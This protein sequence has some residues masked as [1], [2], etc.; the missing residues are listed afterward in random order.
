MTQQISQ[1]SMQ[2]L[3]SISS[4]IK[5]ILKN[6]NNS[7]KVILSNGDVQEL[8]NS[9][10]GYS[11]IV[12]KNGVNRTISTMMSNYDEIFSI[13]LMD[14]TGHRYYA[15][16]DVKNV[17]KFNHDFYDKPWERARRL[18][19]ESY[20]VQNGGDIFKNIGAKEFVSNIRIVNDI[21]TQKPIGALLINISKVELKQ[22]FEDV[23][24]REGTQI[25]LLDDRSDLITSSA[26]YND[27]IKNFS[28]DVNKDQFG[29][30]IDK[31]SNIIYSYYNI[32]E[33]NWKIIAVMPIGGDKTFFT[34]MFASFFIFIILA[35]LVLLGSIV[36]AKMITKPINI[37][38]DSMVN[39]G[40]GDLKKVTFDT[41]I[42][43]F[44]SLRDGYNSM[45]EEIQSLLN[46][47]ITQEKKKRRAELETLQAQIK[48]HFLYNTFD[49]IS[50]LALMGE[51]KKVYEMVSSLGNFY[52]ISLSKGREIITL[53]QELDALKSY[54]DILKVRYD[55]FTVNFDIC[56]EYK[57]FQ[58]L[59]LILQPF[60]ENSIY[61]GIKPKGEPG[62][63][64]ISTYIDDNFLNIK[65]MD[66]GIGMEEKE[67]KSLFS[68]VNSFGIKGTIQR[69]LLYYEKEDLVII[70]S[71]KN[72]G[73][74]VLIKIPISK[75]KVYG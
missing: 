44:N 55:N 12:L 49:S 17:S 67:I 21:K 58:V 56:E 2:T 36:I 74:T 63:I 45:T 43:E 38:V 70:K 8:L 57:D 73:T 39:M 18:N 54:L 1:A 65:L 31:K 71:Q 19:G 13:Y 11:E 22:S 52:R 53:N 35:I 28:R 37:L 5:I 48:P 42:Q 24:K 10:N 62:I 25:F 34:L 32:K 69:I 64:D 51:N 20:I 27:T 61:H 66:D 7:S 3:R 15:D 59:K 30:M 40:K 6:V 72:V 41:T 50:S 33:Y 29:F 23:L 60:I 46:R 4:N 9:K 47:T 75:D 16:F 68:G 26:L 14:T